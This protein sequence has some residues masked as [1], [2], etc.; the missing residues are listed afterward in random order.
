[1]IVNPVS[2]QLEKERIQKIIM[3]LRRQPEFLDV[4]QDGRKL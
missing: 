2:M 4:R 3:E 1:M